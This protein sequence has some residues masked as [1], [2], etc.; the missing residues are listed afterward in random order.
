MTWTNKCSKRLSRWRDQILFESDPLISS[1][2]RVPDAND[3]V[4][5]AHWRGDMAYFISTR[6]PLS[7]RAVAVFAD[8]EA[9]V[10]GDGGSDRTTP[11]FAFGRDEAGHEV[12]I[13]AARFAS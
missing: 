10:F 4:A 6:F 13:F 5:V 8:E 12:L 7:H 11:D 1:E 2:H 9:A 3:T